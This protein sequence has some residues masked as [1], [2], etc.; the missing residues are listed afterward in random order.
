[1][2]SSQL[3]LWILIATLAPFDLM[4]ICNYFFK[5]VR[6]LLLAVLDPNIYCV[7]PKS[8]FIYLSD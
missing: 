6:Q 3:G 7:T 4:I 8:S 2:L 1:M 5:L